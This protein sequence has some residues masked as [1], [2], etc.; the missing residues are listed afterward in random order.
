MCYR[1]WSWLTCSLSQEEI[2]EMECDLLVSDF[3]T[4]ETIELMKEKIRHISEGSSSHCTGALK[5]GFEKAFNLRMS[6]VF[7]RCPYTSCAWYT[8]HVS[9]LAIGS[10]PR[11]QNCRNYGWGDRYLLCVGCGH[12]RTS[13]FASCQGCGKKFL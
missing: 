7:L 12:T 11:C 8:N 6:S 13:N 4:P 1:Q 9:Y 3:N 10:N 5:L 2:M